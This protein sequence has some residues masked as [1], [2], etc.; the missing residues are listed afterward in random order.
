MDLPSRYTLACFSEYAQS[1][2]PYGYDTIT[3]DDLYEYQ[4]KR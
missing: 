1:H 4:F 3:D 2:I